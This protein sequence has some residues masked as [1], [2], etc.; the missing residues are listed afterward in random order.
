M[1]PGTAFDMRDLNHSFPSIRSRSS[2]VD[3]ATFRSG[4]AMIREARPGDHIREQRHY[5]S[6]TPI[7]QEVRPDSYASKG[8][9]VP[10]RGQPIIKE[11]RPKDL[12]SSHRLSKPHG[13][14]DDVSIAYI[15]HE[16]S[17]GSSSSIHVRFEASEFSSRDTPTYR[18]HI[19]ESSRSFRYRETEASRPETYRPMSSQSSSTTRRTYEPSTSSRYY[20][21]ETMRPRAHRTHETHCS[22]ASHSFEGPL[23]TYEPPSSSYHHHRRDSHSRSFLPSDAENLFNTFYGGS[24]PEN[25]RSRTHHNGHKSHMPT[26]ATLKP[27]VDLYNILDISRT[28]TQDDIKKAHRKLSMKYHPDRV[29]GDE[30]TVRGAT[31]KMAEI[32]RAYDILGNPKLRREY[33]LTGRIP[34]HM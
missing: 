16:S 3:D 29:Q 4:H 10:F 7:I 15:R 27:E 13:F 30:E 25:S 20:E 2:A 23:R 33:D 11:I 34:E 19:E 18:T 9:V 24:R 22:M 6:M 12:R 26:S 21:A 31:N 28:V 1:A 8:E 32:N 17:R 5:T 14:V